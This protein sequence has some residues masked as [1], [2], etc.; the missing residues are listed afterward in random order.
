MPFLRQLFALFSKA[1]IIYI[2]FCSVYLVVSISYVSDKFGLVNAIKITLLFVVV[3]GSI[4]YLNIVYLVPRLLLKS[5]ILWF[6][7][8][9][10]ASISLCLPL[11][12]LGIKLLF[13]HQTDIYHYYTIE[14]GFTFYFVDCSI[15]V[16]G[17]SAIFYV[18][19][20]SDLSKKNKQIQQQ[21]LTAELNYLKS[22]I[23]P[24]FLFNILNSIYALARKKSDDTPDAILKLSQ[25]MRYMLHE[26]SSPKVSLQKEILYLNNFIDLERLRHKKNANI[27]FKVVGNTHNL[28][29]APLILL[30]FIENSFKHGLNNQSEDDFVHIYIVVEQTDLVL[31]V[32]NS[33]QNPLALFAVTPKKSEIGLQNVQRRLQLIYPNQYSLNVYDEATTYEVNVKLKIR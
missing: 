19:K 27:I 2:I 24:H 1:S 8:L 16:A 14:R 21:Q 32:K 11:T 25:M 31:K 6:S 13:K 10:L 23:N 9:C 3:Q 22:Q 12:H 28:Q 29:I 26:C 5:K 7:F 33:K 15:A 17:L 20:L 4:A 30:P 18:N